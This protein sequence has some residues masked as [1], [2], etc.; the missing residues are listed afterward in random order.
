MTI[1]FKSEHPGPWQ[2]A[3]LRARS[4]LA[5]IA[6]GAA[7]TAA[8]IAF[9]GLAWPWALAGMGAL[10]VW[11]AAWPGGVEQP[12][13]R[14]KPATSGSSVHAPASTPLTTLQSML[15][16]I[17]DAALLLDGTQHVEAANAAASLL[18]P[19]AAGRH[20]AQVE[21]APELLAAV[22]RA[23]QTGAPQAFE[24][25]TAVPVAR[26]LAGMA[27]PL[28]RGQRQPED[29]AVL[30]VLRD[31]TEAEQLAQM[32][33]DFV[34]NASHELRTPL[35]SLKGFVETL[36]GAAKDDPA[37]RQRF[38]GIMQEQAARMSR[39]IEDLLSLSRIEMRE[40]VAPT[41]VVDLAGVAREASRSL[42]PGAAEAGIAI[43]ETSAPAAVPVIG[44]HDELIQVA[45]NLIQNAIKYGRR[46]GR[47]GVAVRREGSLAKL[48]VSDDGI[49]IAPEHLPRLTERFYR[50]SAKDSRERGGTGLGLAI[51]K[52][53]VNRHRGELTIESVPGNGST[54]TV[55]LPA[56]GHASR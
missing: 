47:V 55:I 54:F 30:V 5:A 16:G 7:L 52:H 48:V 21:R 33:A 13:A 43:D 20:I 42:S 18:F 39:L 27:T 44:D 37:A 32:R 11:A 34:A 29:P 28:G 9:G 45:H 6:A 14:S 36:Q 31:R 8:F 53:I 12:A 51:V 4:R 15:D 2:D 35:A 23:L 49:G 19:G 56:A 40:H 1:D 41:G 22:D 50:V 10:A 38:L 25:R 3:W 46:G 26:L 24:L 17:P